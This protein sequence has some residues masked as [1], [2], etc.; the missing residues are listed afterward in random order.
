MCATGQGGTGWAQQVG[1]GAA[2]VVSLPLAPLSSCCCSST[3]VLILTLALIASIRLPAAV[4]NQKINNQQPQPTTNQQPNNNH[5]QQP[6]YRV[7]AAEESAV[8][9]HL[10]PLD[11][12]DFIEASSAG[13][14]A[15]QLDEME[16]EEQQQQQGAAADAMDEGDGA[17]S[18]GADGAAA[19]A[20]A[21]RATRAALGQNAELYGELGQHNPRRARAEARRARRTRADFAS[22]A[23]AGLADDDDDDGGSDFDFDAAN[24]AAGITQRA[25]AD[26]NDSSGSPSDDGSSGNEV[27]DDDSQGEGEV[28]HVTPPPSLTHSPQPDPTHHL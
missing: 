20:A 26:G 21:A 6:N 9:Q 23:A 28:W 19:V 18:G 25:A 4:H 3:F 7:F 24:E 12:A 15:L 1:H 13:Q 11:A 10:Q 14:V 5:Y 8:I 16:A 17:L 27:S 2:A 22:A